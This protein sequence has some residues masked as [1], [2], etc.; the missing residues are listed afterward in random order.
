MRIVGDL[1]AKVFP[2]RC[3]G[4]GARGHTVCAACHATMPGAP[5]LAIPTG[6]D[7]WWSA[8]AYEGIVRDL[9]ARAKF[10]DQRYVLAWLA[11]AMASRFAAAPAFAHVDAVCWIPTT[12]A[13]RRARGFDQAELLAG[14]FVSQVKGLP[15]PAPLLRADPF[16]GEPSARRGASQTGRSAAERR[17]RARFAP[18]R[19]CLGWSVVVVDDVSTTGA[20]LA[21]AAWSLRQAGATKVFAITAARTSPPNAAWNSTGTRGTA[22]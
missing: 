2:T 11:S 16:E 17:A 18:T 22:A 1:S 20:T 14:A 9:V 3:V 5:V 6:L 10:R 7:A 15:V 4:C 13:R 19:S 21:A 12:R 8:Y